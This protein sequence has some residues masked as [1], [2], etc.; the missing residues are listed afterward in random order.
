ML[1]KTEGIR[2]GFRKIGVTE[3]M[4]RTLAEVQ[5][6]EEKINPDEGVKE[7]NKYMGDFIQSSAPLV[8]S[9]N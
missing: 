8:I 4:G 5:Y 1:S 9:S 3:A 2:E 6:K 7:M